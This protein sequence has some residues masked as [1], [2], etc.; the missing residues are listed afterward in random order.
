MCIVQL[1][2]GSCRVKYR[3]AEVQCGSVNQCTL[4]SV[5]LQDEVKKYRDAEVQ[6]YKSAEVQCGPGQGREGPCRKLGPTSASF[7]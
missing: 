1:V 4:Y 7:I 5:Q 2:Q 6:K 3:S